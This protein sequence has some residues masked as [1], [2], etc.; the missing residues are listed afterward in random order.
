MIQKS[1]SRRWMKAVKIAL[2]CV[3]GADG[4]LL[5]VNWRTASSAP[6]AQELE[7]INL[8]AKARQYAA[9]VSRG[10]AIKKDLPQVQAECNSFY[11]KDLLP[12]STGYSAIIADLGQMARDAGVQTGNIGFTQTPVKDRDLNEVAI[13]ATVQ[14]DYPGLIRLLNAMENSRHFYVLDSLALA[15]ETS[16]AIKLNLVL[17]TYFRT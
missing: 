1:N 3:L 12:G 4:I 2:A 6:Q 11:E 14:G 7:R 17:R 15:S 16:G 8:A 13:A 5:Y 9:D 10:E